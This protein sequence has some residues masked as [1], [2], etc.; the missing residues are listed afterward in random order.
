MISVNKDLAHTSHKNVAKELVL[1]YDFRNFK[2]N[3]T[4]V[5]SKKLRCNDF[6]F[7][8][9]VIIFDINLKYFYSVVSFIY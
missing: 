6:F 2:F 5:S 3:V 1:L 9:N 7:T 4:C 8:I